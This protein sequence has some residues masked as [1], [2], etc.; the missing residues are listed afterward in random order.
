[1]LLMGTATDARILHA[2]L[3]RIYKNCGR[4]EL[5]IEYRGMMPITINGPWYWYQRYHPLDKNRKDVFTM[6]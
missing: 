5:P 2:H 3:D 4:S 6:L 1:M